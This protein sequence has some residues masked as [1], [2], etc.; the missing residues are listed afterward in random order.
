MSDFKLHS[1]IKMTRQ[2]WN[3]RD[4]I[5]VPQIYAY[6]SVA[7]EDPIKMASFWVMR[8]IRSR[9]DTVFS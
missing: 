7:T 5:I 2:F 4:N 8:T 6:T 3:K 1:I 9:Y